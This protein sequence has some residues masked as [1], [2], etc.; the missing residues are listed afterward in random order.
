MQI[1]EEE[2]QVVRQKFDWYTKGGWGF[3]RITSELNRRNIKPKK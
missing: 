2:A 1:N 3:K